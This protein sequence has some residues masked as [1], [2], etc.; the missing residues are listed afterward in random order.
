MG[1]SLDPTS[2]NPGPTEVDGTEDEPVNAAG[3]IEEVIHRLGRLNDEWLQAGDARH[4]F[5]GTYLRTTVAIA[6]E[7]TTPTT[8]GFED[9]TWLER[10]DVAF[11]LLYLDAVDEWDRTG[12][13]PDLGPSLSRQPTIGRSARFA[14]CCWV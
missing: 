6:A 7:I 12:A 3:S 2:S 13:A 11:A 4:Y 5:C 10:W 1:P 8:V 14:T 9:P